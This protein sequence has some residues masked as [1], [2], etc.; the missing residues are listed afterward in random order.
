MYAERTTFFFFL[1][2]YTRGREK[3]RTIDLRFMR[4]DL[5]PIELSLET[6]IITIQ[7]IKYLYIYIYI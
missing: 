3:I 2:F 1:T 5:Q 7:N 6:I 4:H